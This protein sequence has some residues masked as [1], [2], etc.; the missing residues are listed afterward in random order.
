MFTSL[1]YILLGWIIGT[2]FALISI[3]IL[4]KTDKAKK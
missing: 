4:E 1:P 2:G 3:Y